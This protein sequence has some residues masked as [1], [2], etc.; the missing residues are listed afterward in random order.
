MRPRLRLIAVLVALTGAV[1]AVP[2]WALAANTLV[3]GVADHATVGA[4]LRVTFSGHDNS[5]PNV[6]GTFLAAVL[7]P[8]ASAGGSRCRSDL[9]TTEQNHPASKEIFFQK[10]LDTRHTGTY[11]VSRLM[12]PLDAPG[13]WTVC[14]W[15]FNNDGRTNTIKSASHAQASITV[16]PRPTMRS[17]RRVAQGRAAQDVVL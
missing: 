12:P 3:I 8:P 14:A 17:A 10:L 7:E 9:A 6:R 13:R 4:R 2:A 1:S 11:G 5:P 16:V 15:Q